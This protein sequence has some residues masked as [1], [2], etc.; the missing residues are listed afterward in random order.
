MQ[1]DKRFG[2]LMRINAPHFCAGADFDATGHPIRCA[3]ILGASRTLREMLRWTKM[4]RYKS[5]ILPYCD[6]GGE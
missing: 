2:F 1:S 3:P 5:E 6:A 4:K